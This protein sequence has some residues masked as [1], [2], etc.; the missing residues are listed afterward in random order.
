MT[1]ICP[2]CKMEIK[3]ID[4]NPRCPRCHSIVEKPLKCEDCKGCSLFRTCKK[5]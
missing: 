5:N 1:V 4:K 2:T 3:D